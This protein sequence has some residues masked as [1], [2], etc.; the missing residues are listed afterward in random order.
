M[1]RPRGRI[2]QG[3]VRQVQIIVYGRFESA[4]EAWKKK[5]GRSE[6]RGRRV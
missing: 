1:Q 6:A 5:V 4:D 3:Q 2:K